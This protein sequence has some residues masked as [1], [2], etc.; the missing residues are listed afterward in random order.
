MFDRSAFMTR[1]FL[2]QL[3]RG[4]PHRVKPIAILFVTREARYGYVQGRLFS[5]DQICKL[6]IGGS[7]EKRPLPKTLLT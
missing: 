5:T 7:S 4:R 6:K 3:S 1:G 2:A